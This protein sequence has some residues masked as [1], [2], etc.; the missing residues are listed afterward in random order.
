MS[1]ELKDLLELQLKNHTEEPDSPV[2][3]S[4]AAGSSSDS[5]RR[6]VAGEVRVQ[7]QPRLGRQQHQEGRTR[8]HRQ[9]RPGDTDGGDE[10]EEYHG[11][12]VPDL[13][14]WERVQ[15]GQLL[16]PPGEDSPP[17]RCQ[18]QPEQR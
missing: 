10:E 9:G 18:V 11:G 12:G 5:P 7:G 13:Q 2:Q 15:G 6:R 14:H 8:H 16:R 17:A 3:G 1:E 4:S